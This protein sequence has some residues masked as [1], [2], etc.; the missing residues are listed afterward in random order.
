MASYEA[1][2]Q[3]WGQSWQSAQCVLAQFMFAQFIIIA[4][5]G[6]FWI[7]R[8]NF[9]IAQIDKLC[10]TLYTSQKLI[11]GSQQPIMIAEGKAE[12]LSLQF[13]PKKPSTQA[14]SYPAI[15]SLHFP[16]FWQGA[17]KQS[18]TTAK[19][20]E[21]ITHFQVQNFLNRTLTHKCN[22]HAGLPGTLTEIRAVSPTVDRQMYSPSSAWV[23][24]EICSMLLIVGGQEEPF[25]TELTVARLLVINKS[26]VWIS[27]PICR[28][29]ARVKKL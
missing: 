3:V 26:M 7:A 8:R 19:M 28:S 16:L 15:R 6:N 20:S 27:C 17:F 18:F 12:P 29:H 14:H 1:A 23:T 5:F 9:E 10:R 22:I 21:Y 25:F 2:E 4:Q 24:A 13:V 11:F